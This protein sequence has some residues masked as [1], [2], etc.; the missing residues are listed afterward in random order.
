MKK[1]M[2]SEKSNSKSKTIHV[3]SET[4]KDT[5]SDKTD[6]KKDKSSNTKSNNIVKSTKKEDKLNDKDL[7]KSMT[8]IRKCI[9]NPNIKIIPIDHINVSIN[10]TTFNINNTNKILNKA[11]PNEEVKIYINEVKEYSNKKVFLNQVEMQL[12]VATRMKDI[13]K[14]KL[15]LEKGAKVNYNYFPSYEEGEESKNISEYVLN[16]AIEEY[17][18]KIP[19]NPDLVEILLKAGAD[20]Y[21]KSISVSQKKLTNAFQRVA[22][23]ALAYPKRENYQVLKLFIKNGADAYITK[24]RNEATPEKDNL[25]SIVNYPLIVLSDFT[26]KNLEF[27]KILL[28]AGVNPNTY[29]EITYQIE[30]TLTKEKFDCKESLT[31]LFCICNQDISFHKHKPNFNQFLYQM[32][33]LLL[34]YK[35]DVNMWN[36][37]EKYSYDFIEHEDNEYKFRFAKMNALHAALLN[38]NIELCFLLSKAG[39]KRESIEYDEKV[40]KFEQLL[41]RKFRIDW[42]KDSPD[43]TEEQEK[44]IIMKETD[45]EKRKILTQEIIKK[46]IEDKEKEQICQFNIKTVCLKSATTITWS[47]EFH[48][49]LPKNLKQT[50]FTFLLCLKRK[51]NSISLR[52]ENQYQIFNYLMAF[53]PIEELY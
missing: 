49:Y 12:C 45:E 28:E 48:K 17:K 19:V 13:K 23:L 29:D 53:H 25:Y 26:K 52:K 6:T 50:I 46:N 32:V 27:L 43:P 4:K 16:I 36:Y 1:T 31:T 18:D 8:T 14:V 47:K 39:V 34:K 15:L 44:E 38:E 22:Y 3:K 35:V 40:I 10:D 42:G 11:N 37:I 2:I 41:D 33:I 9:E 20:V 5:K 51:V 7:V 21:S 30:N 24:F